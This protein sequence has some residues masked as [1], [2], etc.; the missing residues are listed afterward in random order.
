MK[1]ERGYVCF[2]H[3]GEQPTQEIYFRSCH[4]KSSKANKDDALGTIWRRKG[5]RAY[6]YAVIDAIWRCDDNDYQG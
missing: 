6:E 3:C 4:R 5:V 1:R 2:F